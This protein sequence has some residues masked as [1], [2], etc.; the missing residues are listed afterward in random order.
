MKTTQIIFASIFS[1]SCLA[2]AESG[3]PADQT[4]VQLKQD[5]EKKHPSA[6]YMRVSPKFEAP[7]GKHEWLSRYVFVGVAEKTPAGNQIH[8]WK[9]L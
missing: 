9:V 2:G 5:I 4:P 8:Y 6:Y 1:F 3:N 7:A